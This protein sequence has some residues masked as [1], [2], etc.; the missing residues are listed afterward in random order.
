MPCTLNP[1]LIDNEILL[2]IKQLLIVHCTSTVTNLDWKRQ[3]RALHSQSTTNRYCSFAKRQTNA[4]RALHTLPL[5][6]TDGGWTAITYTERRHSNRALHARLTTYWRYKSA[7]YH[8]LTVHCT[9]SRSLIEASKIVPC[10][11]SRSLI[12]AS[13][14]VPCTLSRSLIEAIIK[15]PCTLYRPRTLRYHLLSWNYLSG[16]NRVFSIFS[17]TKLSRT[18]VYVAGCSNNG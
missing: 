17:Q 14:I 6:I 18:F 2:N 8:T 13:W 15:V 16:T 5:P 4:N 1:L 11:L 9:L 10:T 12:E 3:N 7:Y